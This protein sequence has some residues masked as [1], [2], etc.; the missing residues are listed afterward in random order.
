[1]KKRFPNSKQPYA[2]QEPEPEKPW[3]KPLLKHYSPSPLRMRRGG[4]S[5]AVIFFLI[6]KG[7]VNVAQ[8]FGTPLSGEEVVR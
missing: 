7:R 1:L 8:S 3:K 5:I 6:R 2:A 4:F